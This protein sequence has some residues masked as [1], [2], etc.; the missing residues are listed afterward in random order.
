MAQFSIAFQITMGNEG[1]YSDNPN[2]HGGETWKGIA[3]NF[4]PNWPGWVIVDQI[5]GT[6]PANLNQALGANAQLQSEVLAFYKQNY[7]DTESLD[8]INDQQ[9]GNQLFDTAVNMGTGIA[10]RFLQQAINTLKPGAVTVDGQVGPLTIQAANALPAEQLYGAIC[11][12]RKQRYEQII[13]ANPSQAIFE[14]S[15]FSRITPYTA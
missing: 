5:K 8:S 3:R 4:W 11:N 1:G 10:S 2:D 15:W 7:W 14:K 13:A 6:N 9:T 12:L